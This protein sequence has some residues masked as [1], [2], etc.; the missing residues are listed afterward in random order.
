M[1]KIINAIKGFFSNEIIMEDVVPT[2]AEIK[3]ME[4]RQVMLRAK[5]DA[6]Y[7]RQDLINLGVE[8]MERNG[9]YGYKGRVVR[10]VNY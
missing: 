6:E 7:A 8:N 1:N 2:A 4:E 9:S 3:E 5:L 10:R